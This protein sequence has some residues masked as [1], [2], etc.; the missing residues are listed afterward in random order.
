[1]SNSDIGAAL[2]RC[3][4]LLEAQHG[5]PHR[6][7]AYRAA[8]HSVRSFP[9]SVVS[10]ASSGGCK[11]LEGLYGVG[12]SIAAAIEQL[13]RTGRWAM[14]ERLEGAVS[15]EQLF[16]TVPGIGRE[17]A[18]HI[19]EQLGI[20]TLEALEQAAHDGRLARVE[21]FGP[22]RNSAVQL[23]LA[24]MLAHTARPSVAP[25]QSAGEQPAAAPSV[26]ALLE[27]DA[28]YRNLAEQGALPRLVPRR[29]NPAGAAWLP[30]LHDEIEGFHVH[31]LFSNT[32]RAHELKRTHDWVVIYHDRDGI[33]G[34]HT[35]VTERHGP[36]QGRRVVRGRE[37]E[38]AEHYARERESRAAEWTADSM[39][40]EPLPH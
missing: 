27:I 10:L 8:A 16:M 13:V 1:M 39:R 28:R 30:I 25:D 11:A 21:G 19:H 20:D 12:K 7:R 38:S 35:V 5:D 17:L 36:L 22:R 15:P 29:F 3:A 18:C 32:A 9:G 40:V 4:D 37:P 2:E 6:V 14:L 33:T 26:E 23:A 34:Q 24:S 31:V